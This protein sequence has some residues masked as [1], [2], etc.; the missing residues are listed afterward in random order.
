VAG[1]AARDNR[2]RQAAS[3]QVR[4]LE[5]RLE[6]LTAQRD[7]LHAGMVAAATDPGRLLTLQAELAE[8]ERTI[9]EV[10]EAWL[11]AALAAEPAP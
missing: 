2:S 4:S 6:R 1:E 11:A 9:G 3:R 7:D 5:Q 8:V 10:E